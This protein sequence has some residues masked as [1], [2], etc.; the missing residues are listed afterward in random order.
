LP[1]RAI[2]ADVLGALAV[3]HHAGILH[4]DFK[5]ANILF[6]TSGRISG[7]SEGRSVV[8][9]AAAVSPADPDC[10]AA[11]ASVDHVDEPVDAREGF[12]GSR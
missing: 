6:A 4:R 1:V 11:G 5:P 7:S 12:T 10:F 3:V 2:L 8:S 9:V